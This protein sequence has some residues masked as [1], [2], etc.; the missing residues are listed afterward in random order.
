MEDLWAI[1][2]RVSQAALAGGALRP[3]ATESLAMEEAGIPFT[4][5][6]LAH[7]AEK[8]SL[9]QRPGPESPRQAN[10]F[11]PPDPA[12]LVAEVPPAHRC[13]LNKYCVI[14]DHLLLV[15]RD[16]APQEAAL[17]RQDFMAL[18]RCLA[19]GPAL[20]F[21]NGGRA[22]GASQPHKHLQL[23]PLGDAMT[24]PFDP[25]L[26]R[27][28]AA[29]ASRATELPFPHRLTALPED[30]L[31]RPDTAEAWLHRGYRDCLDALDLGVAPDGRVR[32]PYNLLITARWLLLVPR[33]RE[34]VG[35]VSINALGFAGAL[36]A[37]SREQGDA[38]R[39]R[40]LMASLV[41]V[42]G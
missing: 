2:H 3:I 5:R 1:T 30:L 39:R 14:R 4:L 18:A 17:T 36:L 35:G 32:H 20:A 34:R 23:V 24:L 15:T 40:G 11:L 27:A 37:A 12:L 29:G 31:S 26:T 16:F 22:A 8:P 38:L 10:P 9:D 13:V 33:R 21:Y 6:V 19:A 7:L 42:A 25:L 28:A 41:S